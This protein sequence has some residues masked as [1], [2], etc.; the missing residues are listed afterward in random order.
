MVDRDAICVLLPTYNEAATVGDVVSGFRDGGYGN[1][2]VVD[3]DSTDGTRAAAREAGARVETQTGSGKGQAVR[4]GVEKYVDADHVLLADGDDTYR[5][6]EAD[7]MVEPLWDGYD[8]VVGDRFADMEAGAMSRFNAVGNGLFNWLFRHIHGEDFADILSGYRAFTRESF[9]RLQLSATG[10]GI[11]TE[12]AVECARQ[13][14]D[15]TVVPIRYERRPDGS[16]TNLNPVRDGGIILLALYRRAK[17]SNP[18]FY[19]GSVGA[20]SGLTGL[21]IA[22][23]VGVEWVTAGVSHD[24][25]ALVAAFSV[26]FGVQLLMFGVLSD[27][28]LTLHRERMDRIED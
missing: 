12:M 2:L 28:I 24:V 23:Y 3:G 13:G 25:L 26:L 16:E 1:V 27:L 15:T 6:E 8:H 14:I 21:A 9:D 17:T 5:P 19:F 10:F 18:L 22:V 7:R 11:E 4:E 20:L